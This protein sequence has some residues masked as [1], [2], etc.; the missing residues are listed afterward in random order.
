MNTLTRTESL[1]EAYLVQSELRA[2]GIESFIPEENHAYLIWSH[3]LAIGWIRIQ[4][5]AEDLEGGRSILA[6]LRA[7]REKTRHPCPD[8]GSKDSHWYSRWRAIRLIPMIPIGVPLPI[9]PSSESLRCANCGTSWLPV[10][11]AEQETE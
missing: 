6:N 9:S 11:H 5:M 8:C 10:D 3:H 1:D 2:A 7:E 4:V